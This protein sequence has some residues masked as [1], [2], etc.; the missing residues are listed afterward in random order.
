M[1]QSWNGFCHFGA[2]DM[3]TPRKRKSSSLVFIE[4]LED[5]ADRTVS[6]WPVCTDCVS[7]FNTGGD[8]T[9]KV[10][11][12]WADESLCEIKELP[13]SIREYPLREALIVYYVNKFLNEE[14]RNKILVNRFPVSVADLN[15]CDKKFSFGA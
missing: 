13:L 7:Y 4:F 9:M 10:V 1:S 8:L 3:N 11:N 6:N 5:K 15:T 14:I 2:H 12:K